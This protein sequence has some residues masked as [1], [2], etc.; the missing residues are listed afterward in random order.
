MSQNQPGRNYF[1]VGPMGSGKT[2]LGKRLAKV[3]GM[4]FY[5]SDHE[6]ESRTGVDIPYIFE[7][8]GESGFRK[9]EA[10]VI[11]ELTQC[12]G[13]V[14]ATGGGAVE[15]QESRTHLG[16]RG[17]VVY[18]CASVDRQLLRTKHSTNRPLLQKVDR[19]R[20]LTELM[21]RRD[22]LY[23]EIADI[24]IDSDGRKAKVLLAE[25]EQMLDAL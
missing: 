17:V 13:I 1:L 6:I 25:I 4:E 2:T 9:R 8:E 15:N 10:S 12:Q 14:L 24:V 11:D 22:P 21:E 20:V 16:A 19:R 5:D 18:L 7:K 3:R 23:R